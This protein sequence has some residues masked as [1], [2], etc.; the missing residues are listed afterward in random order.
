MKYCTV[1][2]DK[3]NVHIRRVKDAITLVNASQNYYK[4][5]VAS[6]AIELP[7]NNGLIN[8]EQARHHI[9]TA[10]PDDNII[11]VTSNRFDDNWFSH[12]YREC[13]I[14]TT[15]DWEEYFAPPSLRAYLLYQFAQA[16]LS[17]EADLSETML[18]RLVHEPP[19]G[20]MNDLSRQKPDIKIGMVA[21]N[22]CPQCESVLLRYGLEQ[23]SLDAIRSMLGLVRQE[24]LGRPKIIDPLAAFVIMRFTYNDENDNAYKYGVRQGLADAGITVKR[25]DDTVH[26]SQILEQVLHYIERSRFI[27]AKVDSDNLNVYFELG[28]AMGLSKNVLL[29]AESSLILNLPSDLRNWDC[30]TYDKGNYEQLRQRITKYFL[31]NFGM[32]NSTER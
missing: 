22:L 10:Y 6:E 32:K 5:E 30:L 20:C 3:Q 12:E 1:V 8:A 31:D 21:G 19:L 14:V 16:I 7:C 23:R 4:L 13:S 27:V 25:A 2:L 24:A 28:V 17:F 18:L 15:A 9:H 11:C 26:S 29:I